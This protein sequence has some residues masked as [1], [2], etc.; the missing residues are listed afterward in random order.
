MKSNAH[1]V[2]SDDR[3]VSGLGRMMNGIWDNEEI[4]TDGR[5]SREDRCM[6]VLRVY[7]NEGVTK[8]FHVD[9]H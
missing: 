1:Y 4:W 8:A 7:V 2:I 6:G 9:L 3:G 5:W